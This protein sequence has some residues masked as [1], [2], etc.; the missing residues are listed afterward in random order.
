VHNI[1]RKSSPND[2]LSRFYIPHLF[3]L[4]TKATSHSTVALLLWVVLPTMRLQSIRKGVAHSA[5]KG[6]EIIRLVQIFEQGHQVSL[7]QRR[8]SFLHIVCIFIIDIQ[9]KRKGAIRVTYIKLRECESVR[10][11]RSM[12]AW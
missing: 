12:S 6:R 7:T 9:D 8:R 3:T 2:Y 11:S 4:S 1:I 5:N 10:S